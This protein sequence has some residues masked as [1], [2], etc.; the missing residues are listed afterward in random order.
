MSRLRT[1]LALDVATQLT[2][3]LLAL[4]MPDFLPRKYE[5]SHGLCIHL[6]NELVS[7]VKEME[8]G[9]FLKYTVASEPGESDLPHDLRG[10]ALFEWFETRGRMDVV[11]NLYIRSLLP[12]LLSDFC[13]FVLEALNCSRKAKLTVTYALLRKPL[14]DS[15]FHLESIAAGPDDF[16]ARFHNN[17]SALGGHLKSGH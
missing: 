12:A 1:T 15:L 3:H 5:F 8:N 11:N 9:G 13:H 16:L 4:T 6:H 7:M 14:R 17:S 2:G 10:E